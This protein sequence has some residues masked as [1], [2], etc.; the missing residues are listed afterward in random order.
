MKFIKKIGSKL[1]N[2][3]K[4]N[5]LL[6]SFVAISVINA[7]LLRVFTVKFAYNQVKPLL[8]DIAAMLLM[9]SFSFC[10]KTLK[11][12]FRYLMTM[13]VI[14][15]IFVAGN[16]IFILTAF[17]RFTASRRYGCRFQ[18]HHGSQRPDISVGDTCPCGGIPLLQEKDTRVR[19][20]DKA[21]TKAQQKL[22]IHRCMRTGHPRHIRR[23]THRHRLFETPQTVEQRVCTGYFR[24]VR[25]PDKRCDI[26]RIFPYKYGI[27]LC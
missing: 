8:A 13:N 26:Q 1:K 6:L 9:G 20:P 24:Y 18:E 19:L 14:N 16:S 27:R 11:G 10:F 12:R 15:L 5:P 22:R 21:E 25:I 4:D 23:Y 3:C 2:F 17:N 7:F